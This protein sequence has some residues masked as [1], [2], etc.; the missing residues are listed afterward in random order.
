MKRLV[1][2]VLLAIAAPGL[3]AQTPPDTG[4]EREGKGEV[5]Q[6]QREL[7]QRWNAR[8]R[9]NLGLSND[10]ATRLQT[11]EDTYLAQRRDMA[12][13]QR[14]INE[15]M[16][17]QLQPGVAANEDSVRKLMAARERNRTSLTQLERDEDREIAGYL[18]PVQHA[19]YQMM[20]EQ[21][22]QRIQQL[23]QERRGRGG[24]IGPHGGARRR[25]RP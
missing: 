23:R 4:R 21:L 17:G 15:A 16:R 14:A 6:L 5:Q 10:Q 25:P 12:Q 18:N 9:D 3:R 8:V 19:R 11:T 13:R 7:R 20:R 22:R 1:W 24:A 2:V